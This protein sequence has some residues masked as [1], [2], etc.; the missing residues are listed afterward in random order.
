MEPG[1]SF[2]KLDLDAGER[3]VRLRRELG[4]ES[5]GLNL[6]VLEPGQ[7]S[8]IHRHRHQEEAY[9]V[10]EGELP[11]G[12]SVEVRTYSAEAERPTAIVEALPDEAWETRQRNDIRA[13]QK[14]LSAQRAVREKRGEID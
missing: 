4:I 8:R 7:G 9:V 5:F 11:P 6:L 14:A 3:F 12:T 2:T 1:T 13:A 10:L